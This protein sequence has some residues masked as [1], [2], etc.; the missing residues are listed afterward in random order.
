MLSTKLCVSSHGVVTDLS[1]K[2]SI[3]YI[4]NFKAMITSQSLGD[5]LDRNHRGLTFPGAQGHIP[6]DFAVGPLIFQI[7]GQ[8]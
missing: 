4:N 8:K 5:S 6:L 1:A 3:T 7:R 2:E